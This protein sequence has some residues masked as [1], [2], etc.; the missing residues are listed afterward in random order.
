MTEA[1][2]TEGRAGALMTFAETKNAERIGEFN[3]LRAMACILVNFARAAGASRRSAP[4]PDPAQWPVGC[5]LDPTP[6]GT[7][8]TIRDEGFVG[9]SDPAYGNAEHWERVLGWLDAYLIPRAGR[10]VSV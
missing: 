8:V 5:R 3:V 2:G 10:S 6:A 4:A 1:W 9:R 7:R